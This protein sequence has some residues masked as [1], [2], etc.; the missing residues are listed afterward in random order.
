MQNAERAQESSKENKNKNKNK[1]EP[2][3]KIVE[4]PTQR[5]SFTK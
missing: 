5:M 4:S 2:L 1:I 3:K